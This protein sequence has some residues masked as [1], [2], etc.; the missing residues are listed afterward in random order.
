MHG[1]DDWLSRGHERQDIAPLYQCDQHVWQSP[2]EPCPNCA[3]ADELIALLRTRE[4]AEDAPPNLCPCGV[5]LDRA[6]CG[7]CLERDDE[8][9]GVALAARLEGSIK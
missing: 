9:L 3:A 1:L 7:K 5:N 6:M 4:Y 8:E 2:D